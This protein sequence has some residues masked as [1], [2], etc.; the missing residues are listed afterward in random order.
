MIVLQIMMDPILPSSRQFHVLLP[1]P[2]PLPLLF[3]SFS[4]THRWRVQ[5][6]PESL[7]HFLTPHLEA[8]SITLALGQ[9]P[10]L[11]ISVLISLSLQIPGL[12]FACLSGLTL[13]QGPWEDLHHHFFLLPQT[14]L[15]PLP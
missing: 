7:S 9:F 12:N 6:G 15:L 13:W 8:F 10:L 14:C 3:S 1:L 2:P 11:I 5:G 4:K